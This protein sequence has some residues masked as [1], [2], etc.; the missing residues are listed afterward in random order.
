MRK[1]V[2]GY[3]KFQNEV[4][5]GMR[6]LFEQLSSGQDP[7]ILFI[8]CADSRIMP[9]LITQTVPGEIFACRNAGNI[10]PA[11]GDVNAGG[12]TGT[13]EYAVWALKVK[14]VIVCGHSDCGAM[15]ALIHPEKVAGMPSVAAWLRHAETARFVTIHN[16]PEADENELLRIVIQENVRAQIDNL[17]THPS[18][19]ARRRQGKL[20]LHGWVYDIGSGDILVLNQDTDH[21][22]PFH[23]VYMAE[24]EDVEALAGVGND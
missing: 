11:Y 8:T 6:E 1:I 23:Q 3:I 5:P 4:Y 22:E 20:R 17:E 12:V 15:K 7:D 18:V 19:A 21:F 9:S 10:V 16:H 14:H 24:P 13:I 2:D